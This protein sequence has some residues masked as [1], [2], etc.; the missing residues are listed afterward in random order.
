VIRLLLVI[1]TLVRGGAEKQL[2]LLAARLPREEF[3]VHVAVLTHTGPLESDLREAG[4]PLEMIDKRWKLDP[5][6]YWRLRKYMQK[7]QPAIVHTWL[8]AANAYWRQ[9]AVAARVPHIVAGER[10]V[11]PWKGRIQL[12]IDRA[13]ARRTER[14]VTN[15]SGVR[16]FYVEHGLPAEKFTIIPNGIAAAGSETRSREDLLRELGLPADARLVGA[17]GRLWPQKRVK[18]LIWAADLLKSARDDTH[19]LIIGDG[20]QRWRL[21]RYRDQNEVADRVHFLGERNDVPQ[22]MPH[23]DCLWLASAYEGQSNAIMEAMLAGVPVVATDIPGNRDLVV[24]G[25]TGFLVPVGDRAA[26]ARHTHALLDDRDLASRLGAAGQRRMEREF[27]I[28]QMVSRHAELYRNLASDSS[29]SRAA[30][31]GVAR[32]T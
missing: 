3:D 23:L 25:E 17:V 9:A 15:S 12:G 2:A 32:P 8:F 27:S 20:P 29:R 14:I 5:T 13:L 21:E 10:C 6:A 7:L 22:I 4:I 18:D 30:A 16:D 28:E 1:P 19:L 31:R 24:P 11:D 26:F